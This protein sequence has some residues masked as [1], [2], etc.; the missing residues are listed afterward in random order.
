MIY[1]GLFLL[2]SRSTPS[3]CFSLSPAISLPPEMFSLSGPVTELHVSWFARGTE[4]HYEE[5]LRVVSCEL[6]PLTH[7]EVSCENLLG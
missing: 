7:I 6:L 4:R 3:P 5:R 1:S 2:F